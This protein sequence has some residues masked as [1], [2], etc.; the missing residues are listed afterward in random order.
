MIT[1]TDRPQAMI[2]LARGALA[3]LPYDRPELW[4][5]IGQLEGSAYTAI[6]R[7]HYREIIELRKAELAQRRSG[8]G[9]P[10]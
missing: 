2:D 5:E 9:R 1:R 8:T 4:P 10:Q 6:D 7:E 3:A